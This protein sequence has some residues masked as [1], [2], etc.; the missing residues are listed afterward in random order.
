MSCG[1]DVKFKV[2]KPFSKIANEHLYQNSDE[3]RIN[4]W[5][6]EFRL[7]FRTVFA[8]LGKNSCQLLLLRVLFVGVVAGR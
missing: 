7:S 3:L 5:Q 6:I 4:S 8:V 1:R 2:K